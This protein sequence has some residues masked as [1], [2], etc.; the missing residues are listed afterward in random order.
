MRALT[1]DAD[2][3]A[4]PGRG[5]LDAIREV[6]TSTAEMVAHAAL[7]IAFHE[8]TTNSDPTGYGIGAMGL[9]A[10]EVLLTIDGTAPGL[11]LSNDSSAVA[12]VAPTKMIKRTRLTY[13]LN[14]PNHLVAPVARKYLQSVEQN[15]VVVRDFDRAGT[16]VPAAE[17]GGLPRDQARRG[18][19]I[20]T[21]P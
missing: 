9:D 11:S 5:D 12:I 17:P 7:N 21:V 15:A 18:A 10:P 13:V 8:I 1:R 20:R 19:A 4:G 6:G 3:Q 2:L 16:V 14:P